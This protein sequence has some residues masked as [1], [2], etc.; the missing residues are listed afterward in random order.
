[1]LS[2]P[3]TTLRCLLLLCCAC[4]SCSSSTDDEPADSKTSHAKPK[5]STDDTQSP[6]NTKAEPASKATSQTE[7][8]AN[9]HDPAAPSQGES[10]LKRLERLAIG[11]ENDSLFDV[12][13]LS[14]TLG[15]NMGVEARTGRRKKGI[16]LEMNGLITN[17]T[18]R[19]LI[20][21][22]LQGVLVLH[23]EANTIKI[24]L[25]PDALEDPATSDEP[26][27]PGAV[28]KFTAK[29]YILPTILQ[30]YTPKLAQARLLARFE[31]PITYHAEAIIWS[32][33]IDWL[34][35]RSPSRLKAVALPCTGEPR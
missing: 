27:R 9:H 33:D 11:P 15:E 5:A 1:M 34:I 8:K 7:A 6:P 19:T 12:N 4:A 13:M 32:L 35:T 18:G 3:Q 22:E 2:H 16:I 21:G 17:G 23:F 31:N 30:E 20:N 25:S 28:R 29:T 26:W 10:R 14:L 24:A